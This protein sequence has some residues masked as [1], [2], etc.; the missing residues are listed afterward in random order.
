MHSCSSCLGADNQ[1]DIHCHDNSI[2]LER[3]TVLLIGSK[4]IFRCVSL[5]LIRYVN[6]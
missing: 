6:H 1:P 4:N 2:M 3:V 5:A